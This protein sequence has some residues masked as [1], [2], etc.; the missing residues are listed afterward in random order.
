MDIIA[1]PI[2]TVILNLLA[3][4]LIARGILDSHSAVA[5]I[6]FG[7]NAIA[8]I[9]TFGVA[10]YSIYKMVDLKKHGMTLASTVPTATKTETVVTVTQPVTPTAEPLPVGQSGVVPTPP[11]TGNV[12]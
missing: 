3:S 1:S 11:L 9:M 5:F 10:I 4:A 12:S 7:N 6:Q 8:G 2:I